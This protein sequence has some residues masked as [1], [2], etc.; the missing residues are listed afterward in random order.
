MT[1]RT[2]LRQSRAVFFR[3]LGIYDLQVKFYNVRIRDLR[4]GSSRMR[5]KICDLRT[6]KIS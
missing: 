6:L 2:V 3:N 1:L 4:T 5:L